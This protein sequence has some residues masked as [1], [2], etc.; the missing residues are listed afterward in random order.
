[1]LFA[2]LYTKLHSTSFK[3]QLFQEKTASMVTVTVTI[4][5]LSPRYIE[6]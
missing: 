6:K 3:C 2:N 1:M 4:N 5:V